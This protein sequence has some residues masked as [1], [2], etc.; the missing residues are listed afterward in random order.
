MNETQNRS[1][2]VASRS[3]GAIIIEMLLLVVCTGLFVWLWMLVSEDRVKP[4]DD[5]VYG[6]IA[7][8][9][10][11]PS[12]TP[13]M[14]S[15]TYMGSAVPLIAISLLMLILC[16]N[17][18]IGIAVTLNLALIYG[19][20]ELLKSIMRRPRPSEHRL[21]QEWGFSFPSGHAMVNT[22]FYGFLIVLLFWFCRNGFLRWLGTIV[23]AALIVIIIVSRVYLGVHYPSDVSAGFL[24]SLAYLIVYA[25]CTKPWIMKGR[26]PK[27]AKR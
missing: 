26:K 11:D 18:R 16:R 25:A 2:A 17:R 1:N 9:L 14:K 21:I 20:N 23:L 24:F 5:A 15:C 12:V 22:A 19:L 10:I 8:H 13:F 4:F 7:Q 27:V 3:A 6:W